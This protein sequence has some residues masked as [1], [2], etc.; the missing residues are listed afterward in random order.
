VAANAFV[1]S[2]NDVIVRDLRREELDLLPQMLYTALDWR[3]NGTL[4]P[5]EF[6]VAHPQVRIFHEGWGRAGDAALVAEEHDRVVGLV[7]YRLFTAAEHGE[8]FVDERTP[9]VAIAVIDGCRGRG[10]G[11]ALMEA[12]HD[13]ARRDGVV[14]LS[15]SVDRDN[16]ARR[17]YLRLGYVDFKPDD[18]L[19]RMELDLPTIASTESEPT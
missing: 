14:R 19:G 10:I 13:R 7:W 18:D 3:S 16:P 17:L 5:F 4:P 2:I 11:T 8:G 12:I 1:L 15:L 9:E 6:V